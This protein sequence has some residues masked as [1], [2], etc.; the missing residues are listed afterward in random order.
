MASMKTLRTKLPIIRDVADFCRSLQRSKI[1]TTPI[2]A[3][4]VYERDT[5][6]EL[7]EVFESAMSIKG[8]AERP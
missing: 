3:M 8:I 4:E 5:P 6:L 2:S 7:F 1:A